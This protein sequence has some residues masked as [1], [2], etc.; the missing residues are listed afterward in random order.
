MKKALLILSSIVAI[1]L[2]GCAQDNS[3][4]PKQPD[5]EVKT[6]EEIGKK[7]PE[8]EAAEIR[9]NDQRPQEDKS[10]GGI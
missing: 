7:P 2:V 4:P 1:A 5:V 6:M 8:Q 3:A 10:E 9:Q